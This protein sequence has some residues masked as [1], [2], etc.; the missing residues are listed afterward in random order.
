MMLIDQTN[1]D[2]ITN[3][4]NS[5]LKQSDQNLVHNSPHNAYFLTQSM[6]NTNDLVKST[7]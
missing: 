7:K 3:Y 6:T 1:P 4:F 2:R 5:C